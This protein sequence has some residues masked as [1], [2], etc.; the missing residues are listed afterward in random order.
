[1]I[2]TE[3]EIGYIELVMTPVL[4]RKRKKKALGVDLI[5]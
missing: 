2:G 4:V 5:G 1:M 3:I